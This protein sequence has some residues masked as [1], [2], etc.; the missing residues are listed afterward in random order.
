MRNVHSKRAGFSLIELLAVIV[1]LGILAAF[2][3]PRLAGLGDATRASITRT[4]ISVIESAIRE[5]ENETGDFPRSSWKDEWG[6]VPNGINLG[7]EVL[8]VSLWAESYGGVTIKEDEL[9]NSDGDEA[10]KN[11]TTLGSRAL[12]ELRDQWDNPIAYFHRRDYDRG[13]LYLTYDPESG[14]EYEDSVKARVSSKT[15]SPHNP[16]SFQLISAGPNGV[17]GDEDDIAN[18]DLEP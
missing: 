9:V 16:R 2:L 6:G 3:V 1:I 11:L 18:F 8:F 12:F 10:R 7:A 4:Q 15:K 13:D 17:F 14:E 5:Y